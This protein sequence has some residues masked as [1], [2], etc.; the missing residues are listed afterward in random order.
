[1]NIG[2]VT[3]NVYLFQGTVF[4]NILHSSQ[5]VNKEDVITKMNEKKIYFLLDYFNDG[6][7]SKITIGG[8]N[9][10]GGQKQIVS[11]IRIM[12][13]DCDLLIL[14]ELSS[15]LD[16]GLKKSI[17]KIISELKDKTILAVSHEC[18]FLNGFKEIKLK[19]GGEY[20]E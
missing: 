19:K 4:E 16:E 6:L 14:D 3:Q 7:E 20:S 9:L 18:S 15:N 10:S 17:S 8:D 1:M 11:F 12:L 13:S 5:C 2:V